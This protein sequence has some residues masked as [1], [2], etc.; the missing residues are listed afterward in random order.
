VTGV[1]DSSELETLKRVPLFAGL[2][3]SDLAAV[4][5]ISRAVEFDP[6]A[7]LIHQDEPGHHFFVVLNGEASVERDGVEINRLGEGDFFG[8]ISLLSNRLTTA[9]VVT[10]TAV[11]VVMIAPA[12]FKQLLEELPS[13]QMKVIE[14]LASRLPDEFYWQS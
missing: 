3:R 7:I 5:Q 12:G 10:T 6:G 4:Q 13:M 2:D 8:E 14:A 11:R 9:A 1:Q